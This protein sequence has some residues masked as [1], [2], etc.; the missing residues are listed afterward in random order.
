ML[1][2][3]FVENAFK[4]GVSYAKE[5]KINI[6]L[7]LNKKELIFKVINTINETPKKMD[8]FSGVGINNVVARLK[9]L[10]PGN[11]NLS[12]ED[13]DGIYHVSLVIKY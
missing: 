5:S 12:I 11:H 10:Y 8:E 1:L 7:L 9:L 13:K 6:E 3:P 2:I 4:H